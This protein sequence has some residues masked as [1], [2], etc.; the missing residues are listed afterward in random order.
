MP[1]RPDPDVLRAWLT[2]HD[3]THLL[4][5][6]D[7]LEE[8]NRRLN[9]D[10]IDW[11]SQ[12]GQT[13]FMLRDLDE[14]RVALIWEHSVMPTLEEYFYNRTGWQSRYAYRELMAAVKA[15]HR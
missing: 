8:L 3:K 1:L 2:A 6:A 4:W 15:A 11:Q 13:V 5:V 7:L 10:G 14:R 9:D 12:I